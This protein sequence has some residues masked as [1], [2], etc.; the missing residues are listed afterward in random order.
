[1]INKSIRYPN[2]SDFPRKEIAYAT[3]PFDQ[4]EWD[5][6]K[7]LILKSDLGNETDAVVEPFGKR[8]PDGSVRY[9]RLLA[10]LDMHAWET[11]THSLT[12]GQPQKKLGFRFSPQ[13][14]KGLGVN[15]PSLGI[16][17]S[18]AWK[19]T[20]FGNN[21]TLLEDNRLRKVFQSRLRMGNFIA[22]IKYYVMSRQQLVKFELSITGSNPDNALFEYPF[23]AISF[24]A[25]NTNLANIQAS[26]RRGVKMTRPHQRFTLMEADHFGDGQKQTWYGEIIPTIDF[27]NS[28][29]IA[30]ALAAINFPLNGMSTD[31]KDTKAF[32][33]FG[34]IPEPESHKTWEQAMQAYSNFNQFID[35]QGNVW[36]DYPLGVTMTP[37]Q[38]GG[39]R[40]FGTLEGPEILYLGASE[41]VDAYYFMATEETKRPS[42]FYETDASPVTHANHPRWVTWAGT[43]HWHTSI[44]TDRLGKTNPNFGGHSHGWNGKD[45]QHH[46]SN[47]L[48]LASLLTGSYLLRDE[49]DNEIELFL[50][51]HTLP[52]EF[53]G[54]STNGRREAR[55]FGRPHH[56]MVNHHLL[57]NRKDIKSHMLERFHEVIKSTWDGAN[58]APVRNWAH[59]ADDRVLGR[60]VDA[61]VPWNEGLGLAGMVALYNV[62]HNQEVKDLLVA[63]ATTIVTYGYRATRSNG[64]LTNL[65]IGQGVKWLPDGTALTPEEYLD[66]N[67]FKPAG[68]LILWAMP[69]LEVVANNSNFFGQEI[70]D[71]AREYR[72]FMDSVQPAS[73]RAFSEY[74]RWKAIDIV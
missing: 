38:T 21:L 37:G 2:L 19:W 60:E 54:W 20:Q 58:I 36:D 43:T 70:S 30:N 57:T 50:A 31:W 71:L 17:V 66:P 6:E 16:K 34:V 69:V 41:L 18:G 73:P 8:W 45:W 55:G 46:S 27:Q 4:G 40:D 5:G 24:F 35:S 59:I 1:M 9:G 49:V 51:G 10:R 33:A 3:V 65:E 28:D 67:K 63:W 13:L 39:Q 26:Q 56:A 23:E 32:A 14:L 22:D 48:S 74:G 29:Q 44:S 42:H 7:S 53:P 62:T 15:A 47:L 25:G 64:V 52:S 68:G 72:D 11:Q 61:W 12:E